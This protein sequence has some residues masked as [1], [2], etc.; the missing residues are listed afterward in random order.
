MGALLG[1]LLGAVFGASPAVPRSAP[2][3]SASATVISS[4]TPPRA[5]VLLDVKPGPAGEVTLLPTVLGKGGFGRVV[6]GLY[7]GQPVAVKLILDMSLDTWGLPADAATATATPAQGAKT[8]GRLASDDEVAAKRNLGDADTGMEEDMNEEK[9]NRAAAGGDGVDAAARARECSAGS[10][11]KP[12]PHACGEDRGV[13]KPHGGGRGAGVGM[14]AAEAG[15]AGV[16][17][18]VVAQLAQEVAVL[19]RCHHPNIVNLLAAC[20]TPPRLCLVMERCETSLDKLLYGR[21]GQLLPMEQVVSVALDVA[22]GLEYLHPT[23]VHR[24]LKPG[25]VL[26]NH[27]GGPDM[28]AKLADFGFSRLRNT[29]AVATANPEVGTPEFMAPELYALTNTIVTNKVDV[30]SFGVLLWA[31]LSGK[32]PWEGMPMVVIAVRVTMNRERPAMSDVPADRRL[33]KLE[34]LVRQC[35]DSVPE[36]RPAAAELVKALLLVQEQMARRAG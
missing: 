9:D 3:A 17:G 35:W 4:L 30:Y 13:V 27:P 22:R 2:S 8:C 7:Q 15:Q 33:R 1:G 25:N 29:V 11:P 28:V 14:P 18:F 31:M 24:D 19:S 32:R 6:E 20:L 26:V 34:H 10:G 12:G 23:I 5:D 21:P 36:R 16:M